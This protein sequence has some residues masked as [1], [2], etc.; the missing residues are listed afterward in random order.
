MMKIVRNLI[1]PFTELYFFFAF[2]LL[3]EKQTSSGKK[4]NYDENRKSWN[5]W[6]SHPNKQEN[7][8]II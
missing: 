3:L 2:S 5:A 4:Q 8:K 6:K 7:Y 1:R